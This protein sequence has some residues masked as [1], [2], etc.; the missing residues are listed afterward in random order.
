MTT[1]TMPKSLPF[2][3]NS[4]YNGE[5]EKW[6]GWY[7]TL[8]QP[9]KRNV[10]RFLRHSYA[11]MSDESE[12]VRQARDRYQ[13]EAKEAGR[14]PDEEF[15]K[16][17]YFMVS[18]IGSTVRGEQN[19]GDVDLLVVTNR[20]WRDMDSFEANLL[21]QRLAQYFD[22]TID[23]TVSEAYERSWA[24]PNRTL[25]TLH[26]KQGTGKRLHVTVQPEIPNEKYWR[27]HDGDSSVVLCRF[28]D[29]TGYYNEF[30]GFLDCM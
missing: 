19:Y 2:V 30:E 29:T 27:E 23:P 13:N 22:H 8:Q 3:K 10:G 6:L 26:P 16:G 15:L 28:G 4:L 5:G 20:I 18:A 1:A 9:D 14:E 25:V 24:R 7:S 12:Q 21:G 17:D 11:W